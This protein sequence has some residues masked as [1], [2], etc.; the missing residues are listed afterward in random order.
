MH[1][2][3][4]R[5]NCSCSFG[6]QD[7]IGLFNIYFVVRDNLHDI[8]PVT[9][10]YKSCREKNDN[11]ST[12]NYINPYYEK[13]MSG[14]TKRE[15]RL[16]MSTIFDFFNAM[17]YSGNFNSQTFIISLII[18]ALLSPLLC[19]ISQNVIK[20]RKKEDKDTLPKNE[21]RIIQ[22][23]SCSLF[24]IFSAVIS[25]MRFNITE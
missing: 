4:T 1:I 9:L 5:T 8:F 21:K 20:Y 22:I 17:P 6:L 11:H 10:S 2:I 13:L 23:I 18:F 7:K 16:L 24:S 19:V 25:S 14:K 12:I 15:R 3:F